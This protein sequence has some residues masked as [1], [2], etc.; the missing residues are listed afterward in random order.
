[1]KTFIVPLIRREAWG[2]RLDPPHRKSVEVT[3]YSMYSAGVL[4]EG[5]NPGW[6]TATDIPITASPRPGFD[7][8]VE[9]RAFQFNVSP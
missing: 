1:M 3:C 7:F 6:R 2:I 4:A 5:R 9:R 8:T